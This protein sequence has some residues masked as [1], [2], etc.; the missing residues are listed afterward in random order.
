MTTAITSGDS[1]SA[2]S[3]LIPNGTSSQVYS[4]SPPSNSVDQSNSIL[5]H[6]WTDHTSTSNNIQEKETSIDQFENDITSSVI[7]DGFQR[8]F[9]YL[10]PLT[11]TT[12]FSKAEYKQ[13]L[14]HD[15]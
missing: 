3:W 9:Y 10:C 2:P 8:D 7:T 1:S 6:S 13:E 15:V 5:S 14:L 11:N 4:S 12:S